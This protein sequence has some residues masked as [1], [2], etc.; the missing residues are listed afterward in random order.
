MASPSDKKKIDE[1]FD[2]NDFP[3]YVYY[4]EIENYIKHLNAKYW[5]FQEIAGTKCTFCGDASKYINREL[6]MNAC[7]SCYSYIYDAEV[8]AVDAEEH[9][10]SEKIRLD[11]CNW[12]DREWCLWVEDIN[13][14]DEY[15]IEYNICYVCHQKIIPA[16]ED[17]VKRTELAVT[18]N[19]FVAHWD[20]VKDVGFKGCF[21]EEDYTDII[22]NKLADKLK[23]SLAR[24]QD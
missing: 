21:S 20:C 24:D 8:D 16:P 5:I 11:F 15:G 22:R 3:V 12:I 4:D 18:Q 9:I 19:N 1:L 13:Y 23:D 6:K 14:F 10:V 17:S 2:N 7:R